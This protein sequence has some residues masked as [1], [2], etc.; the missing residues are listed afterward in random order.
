MNKQIETL[1]I[2]I[3]VLLL[4][5]LDLKDSV[6]EIFVGD[7]RG[8][9]SQGNHACLN[10]NCLALGAVEIIRTPLKVKIAFINPSLKEKQG[11]N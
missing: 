2:V 5:G 4:L 1:S 3:E 10:A 11:F 8:L 6:H 9:A 7:N